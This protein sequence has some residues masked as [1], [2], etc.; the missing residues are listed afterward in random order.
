MLTIGK[1]YIA[2]ED[3]KARLCAEVSIGNRAATLW[4]AVDCAQESCLAVGRADPFV[5]VLLPGAMRGGHEVVCVDPMSERLHDQLVNGLVP[6]LVSAG[7]LYRSIKITA[8]LTAEGLPNQGAVGT[9]FSGGADCLYTIMRHGKDSEFPLTHIAVFNNGHMRDGYIWGKNVFQITC[10][11]AQRFAEEQG[12]IMTAVDSNIE[13]ILGERFLDVYSFRNYACALALGRLFSVYLLSS[14]HDAA[15]F[16]L[17]L[18]NT[19]TFDL[20]NARYAS[21]ESLSFYH[22]GEEVTRVGKLKALAD[23]EPSWR[24]LHPC[25]SQPVDELNCGH[26]RKCVRDMTVFYALGC[27]DRYKAI[28][29]IDDYLRNLPQ[30][31][32]VLLAYSDR[33]LYDEPF[34]LLKE[35]NI[36][37]PQKAFVYE[38]QFRLAM[39]HLES[40]K[41]RGDL[42]C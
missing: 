2:P 34:Q 6:T 39:R 10:Q 15:N 22:A 9:G 24:W 41:Q 17:D 5:M 26:C 35:R 13:T 16:E 32:G 38:R 36:Q 18:R 1:S 21:T 31:M 27:L 3:G 23:W 25:I 30:R 28:Y 7:E 42:R 37:I 12:L 19:A 8:P 14:G 33:H 4:Y 40:E 20:L 29:D 11:Y